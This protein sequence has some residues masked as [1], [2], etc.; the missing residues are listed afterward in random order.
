MYQ[1]VVGEIGIERDMFLYRMRFWEVR[2]I[3][4]GNRRR[5]QCSWEQTRWAVFW[6]M[7]NGMTD[8]K[9][10]GIS[11]PADLIRFPWDGAAS[12]DTLSDEE[13]EAM[14][15]ALQAKNEER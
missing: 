8:L 9:K 2:R 1:L 5:E 6:L 3:V 15:R 13:V 11:E 10:A 7:H 14:R 4:A 12:D